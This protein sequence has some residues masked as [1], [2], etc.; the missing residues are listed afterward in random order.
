MCC[1]ALGIVEKNHKTLF[2]PFSRKIN[3][4][5]L[6][7][8][9]PPKWQ[10]GNTSTCQCRRLTP[11]PEATTEPRAGGY[12]EAS[13]V[14]SQPMLTSLSSNVIDNFSRT[15][16]NQ[17]LNSQTIC[18]EFLH[19]PPFLEERLARTVRRHCFAFTFVTS[20]GP[21]WKPQEGQRV[22]VSL[23]ELHASGLYPR[24]LYRCPSCPQL[25]TAQGHE[26]SGR[27]GGAGSGCLLPLESDAVAD[28]EWMA[29]FIETQHRP[30]TRTVV[31]K[32]S[33]EKTEFTRHWA[34]SWPL[35]KPLA[36][37]HLFSV[38]KRGFS[39]SLSQMPRSF[40]F[41]MV[42]GHQLK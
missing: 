29:V 9:E 15:V 28:C 5:D 3:G 32:S 26:T 42:K 24:V 27:Q 35:G 14:T 16:E 36:F 12:P 25:H 38:C 2:P 4:K 39:L 6:F 11:P 41:N 31:Y 18:S 7:S 21:K 33:G 37:R 20:W 17:A 40:G 22:A 30:V 23:P 13:G 34:A 10:S 1:L 19:R 8:M